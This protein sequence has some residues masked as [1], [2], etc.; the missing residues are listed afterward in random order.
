MGDGSPMVGAEA[1]ERGIALSWRVWW[2][3]AVGVAA[4]LAI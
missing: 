3:L 1:I 4:L 2:L